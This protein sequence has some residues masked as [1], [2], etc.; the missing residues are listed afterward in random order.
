MFLNSSMSVFGMGKLV[1]Q[2]NR[3]KK[4]KM[5]HPNYDPA[6]LHDNEM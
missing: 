6:N 1:N 3:K 4:L 2:M 5:Y